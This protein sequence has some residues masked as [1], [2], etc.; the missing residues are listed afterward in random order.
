MSFVA[1]ERER[2]NRGGSREENILIRFGKWLT[3]YLSKDAV[4]AAAG[5]LGRSLEVCDQGARV[6]EINDFDLNHRGREGG[7]AGGG[8]GGLS[9]VLGDD[10][11]FGKSK[12]RFYWP[13]I[14]GG[15]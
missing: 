3:K 1:R 13:P 11:T 6:T 15:G 7:G 12:Q 4:E 14:R 2:E 8:A 10:R 9:G 5:A